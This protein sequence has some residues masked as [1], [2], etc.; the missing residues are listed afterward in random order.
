MGSLLVRARKVRRDTTRRLPARRVKWRPTLEEP[1]EGQAEVLGEADTFN[2]LCMGRRWG[3]TRL[4]VRLVVEPMMEGFPVAWLVPEF[5]K[6]SDIWKE[7]EKLLAPLIRSKNANLWEMELVTGGSIKFYSIDR[8][9]D[10]PRGKKFR[11]LVVDEAAFT[12]HLE[13]CLEESVLPTMLDDPA[14]DLWLCSSPRGKN[15]FY[16]Y[17]LRGQEGPEKR[18]GWKSWRKP[19]KTNPLLS[20][21]RLEQLRAEVSARRAKVEYD[22]DFDGGDVFFDDWR[23]EE[24]GKP[25]HVC[26]PFAVPSWWLATGGLDFGKRIF[27]FHL[28]RHG[29]D[30]RVFATRE[31]YLYDKLPTEQAAAV[32]RALEEEQI[33]AGLVVIHAD[34]SGFP[35]ENVDKR[36]GD[37]PVE[38]FWSAGLHVVKAENNRNATNMRALEW[39][40]KVAVI[41]D[42]GLDG[43]T[44]TKAPAFRVFRGRCPNLTRT[45]PMMVPLE[46]DP[47]DFDS[48]LE[49]HAVDS[50]LRYGLPRFANPPKS[51]PRDVSRVVLLPPMPGHEPE[52]RV[53]V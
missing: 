11:R 45:V 8:N 26:T 41:D 27:S 39:L 9:P 43:D 31:V 48:D 42:T 21:D 34:P 22:A 13:K 2:V 28:L 32:V 40:H 49:D 50:C 33:D 3:K 17:W 20:L 23:E 36:V 7:L 10:G 44:G 16:K 51:R 53:G 52:R 12:R 24:D 4:G 37:Y 47:D 46:D 18:K 6:A 30:G 1:H 38:A 5:G 19:T 14:A 29:Q 25:W 15:A 35:P